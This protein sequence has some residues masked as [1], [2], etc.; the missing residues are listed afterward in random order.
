M[1]KYLGISIGPAANDRNWH[2]PVKKFLDRSSQIGSES[3][4]FHLSAS[5]FAFRAISVLGYV[6]QFLPPPKKF[7]NVDL[8][9]A[10]KIL[11]NGNEFDDCKLCI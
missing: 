6:A 2:A 1:G 3:L 11:Q 4:L 10:S 7:R 5:Q 9:A 8:R